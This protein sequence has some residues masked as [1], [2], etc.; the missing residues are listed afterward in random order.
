MACFKEKCCSFSVGY[1]QE[2]A[3]YYSVPLSPLPPPILLGDV[4]Q[5][6]KN[7]GL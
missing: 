3:P 4:L 2:A 6:Q 1:P 7:P 5:K